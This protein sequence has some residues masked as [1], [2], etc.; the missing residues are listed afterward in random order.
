MLTWILRGL[1]ALLVY[2]IVRFLVVRRMK[3]RWNRQATRFVR[4][5]SIQLESA[6]FIDRVWIREA[7]AQDASI[8]HAI[9]DVARESGE[10]PVV[11]RDRVDTYV[12]EIAPYFSLSAYYRFMATLGQSHPF[13][14]IRVAELRNWIDSGDY[15]AILGGD[16]HRQGEPRSVRADLTDA[17]RNFSEQ[18]GKVFEDT[19]RYVND[20]LTNFMNSARR[21]FDDA[22]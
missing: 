12:D 3:R 20:A 7:L 6:R 11:L 10:S 1:A 21:F 14:V 16:Y 15:E 22:I 9:A 17:G 5:H 19:D 8:D 18:A 2:E 4:D 13:P